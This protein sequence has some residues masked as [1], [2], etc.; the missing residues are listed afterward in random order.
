METNQVFT[1]TVNLLR[2]TYGLVPI[3]AG[4]DKFTNILTKWEDYLAPFMKEMLP[5]EAGT[6][7]MIVGVI[8]IV[9]GIIVLVR[10]SV[11]GYIVAAWLTSIALTLLASGTFLDVAVR[12]LVMAIGAFSLAR[13][14]KAVHK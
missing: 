8:E 6:F 14:A 1:S 3:V 2:L 9:A 4:L 10:P 11:G 7:M 12:D 5:F 13:M